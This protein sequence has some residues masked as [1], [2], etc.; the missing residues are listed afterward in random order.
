MSQPNCAQFVDC[1]NVY[2]DELY[3]PFQCSQVPLTP[4]AEHIPSKNRILR[5][6]SLSEAEFSADHSNSPFILEN[7][8]TQWPVSKQW[9]TEGLLKLYADTT[10]RAE[11]VDW[12]LLMYTSY[13]QNNI[14]ESPLY[15]FDSHFVR[16]TGITVGGPDQT[17]DYWAPECFG[18]DLF[19]VLGQDRPDS[20]WLIVGPTRSGSTF[21]KDPNATSAWNTVIQGS[22]YWL[23]FPP[24]VSPPGTYVS[25]DGSSVTSPLSVTEYLLTFHKEA[26]QTTGCKEGVCRAHEVVHVPSGWW[27][28]VVNLEDTVAITQNFVTERNLF[29]TV[30]F[31]RDKPEQVS[32]FSQKISDPYALFM[33]RLNESRPFILQDLSM[34]K[35][36]KWRDLI[37]DSPDGDE[38]DIRPNGFSFGFVATDNDEIP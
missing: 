34:K 9:T 4:F 27:H 24:S 25:A 3:R 31:L 11:A 19:N 29:K 37:R 6:S 38:D 20:R 1:D 23:M 26:R 2:S 30:E 15:L 12:T 10:F 16:K 14:D 35:K 18:A 22:K 8:A 36:R 13:M 33:Q 28:L 32:G 5:C 17:G 7:G 21:H